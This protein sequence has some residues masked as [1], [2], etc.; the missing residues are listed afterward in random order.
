MKIRYLYTIGICLLLMSCSNVGFVI[1]ENNKYIS[2]IRKQGVTTYKADGYTMYGDEISD[3]IYSKN[4]RKLND[5]I[6]FDTFIKI[7]ETDT[8]QLL[9]E[10]NISYKYLQKLYS[11]VENNAPSKLDKMD[12][13]S[14]KEYDSIL[15]YYDSLEVLKIHDN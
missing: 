14:K 9:C 1:A 2:G 15:Y 8:F 6:A 7:S 11:F 3:C 5:I 13:L 12:V 4:I 10:I